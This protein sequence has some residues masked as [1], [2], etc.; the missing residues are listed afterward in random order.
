M[1]PEERAHKVVDAIWADCHDHGRMTSVIAGAI[2]VAVAEEREAC[3]KIAEEVGR[4][5]RSANETSGFAA[6][7][8]V[9]AAILARETP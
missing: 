1:T 6:T 3:A 4:D 9:R 2:R 5:P 8:A 7:R